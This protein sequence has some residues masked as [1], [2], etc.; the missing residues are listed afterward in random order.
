MNNTGEAI[1]DYPMGA[2]QYLTNIKE[3]GLQ[4]AQLNAI[5]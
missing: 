1:I 3:H 5:V 2:A 4:A